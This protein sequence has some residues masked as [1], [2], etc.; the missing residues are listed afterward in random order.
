MTQVPET[1]T[2]DVVDA[3]AEVAGTCTDCP[4]TFHG[5]DSRSNP[6][7]SSVQY[8]RTH[9]PLNNCPSSNS[10]AQHYAPYDT[11]RSKV[12]IGMPQCASWLPPLAKRVGQAD[13]LL[14]S[15]C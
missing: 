1:C 10:S 5:R 15:R 12:G 13:C 9:V 2:L 11:V 6:I 8:P 7:A 4:P 14:V 3:E